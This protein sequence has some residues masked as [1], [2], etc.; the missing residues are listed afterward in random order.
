MGTTYSIKYNSQK[1]ITPQQVSDGVE[2]LLKDFNQVASTYISDSE[3]SLINKS[4]AFENKKVSKEMQFLIKR[5]FEIAKKT[6]EHF[7]PTIGPLV[8]VWGFGPQ[9]R[10]D[11][12]TDDEINKALGLVGTHL[13]PLNNDL[14][15]KLKKGGY[16]D[17][18]AYAK[19]RGVD[20]VFEYLRS[21]GATEIFVEIGG[22]IR[23]IGSKKVW[24][25]GIE[26]PTSENSRS[27]HKIVSL[28]NKSIATSGDYRN[29][30]LLK[31][32]KKIS[33]GI[34]LK[35][36]HPKQN[37]IASV[38]VIADD[39]LAADAWAT[40]LMVAGMKNL[41]ELVTKYSLAVYVIYQDENN[42]DQYLTYQSPGWNKFEE[43]K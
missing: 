18:S 2:K 16:L 12:P 20:L 39:C 42:S 40:G 8:N 38:S 41:K 11:T 4:D 29:V 14:L 32:G 22:E 10:D 28:K 43:K 5:G 33:H 21:V 3:I 34:S 9:K 37:R 7:D 36:G 25:V 26:K 6:N 27:A 23:A 24:R 17:F 13:F 30:K 15:G 1:N 31:S 35:T 19:G